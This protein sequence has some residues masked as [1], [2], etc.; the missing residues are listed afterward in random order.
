MISGCLQGRRHIYLFL[1]QIC[2]GWC[3]CVF[4]ICSSCWKG[5]A[6]CSNE[7]RTAKRRIAHREA[8]KKYRQTEKG[9]I[10]HREAED[11]RRERQ[12]KKN[13]TDMD[14]RGSTPVSIGCNIQSLYPKTTERGRFSKKGRCH[15]C[16][17][18]GTIVDQFPRRRYGNKNYKHQMTQRMKC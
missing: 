3:E 5:Q 1:R 2:C 13:R 9:K 8:Q 14:D 17:S 4:Y 12:A 11:R 7:C 6:Y 18:L 10:A 16:G 15:F